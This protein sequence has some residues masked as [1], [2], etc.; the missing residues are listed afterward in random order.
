MNRSS[1]II[2]YILFGAFALAVF[3]YFRFPSEL[4]KDILISEMKKIEPMAQLETDNVEPSVPPGIKLSPLTISYDDMPILHLDS[5]KI[6]PHIFSMLRQ[7]KRFSFSGNLKDG[8]LEGTADITATSTGEQ[9]LG[10]IAIS[11][12]PLEFLEVLNQYPSFKPDGMMNAKINFDSTKGG[13]SADIGLEITPARI[14]LDPPL[15]DLDTL[16]F[17]LVKAQ[18]TANQRMVQIRSC[19]AGGDQIESKLTGA[20]VLRQPLQES[21]LTLSLTLRPLPAF[22]ADHKNDMIGGLLASGNAQKRGLIFR[23]SG[24][25]DKPRYVI[26]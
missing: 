14:A 24:T 22:L 3:L 12:M 7:T 10:D 19:E 20:I 16:E 26:R 11:R 23:I 25:L 5:L 15:M 13:G 18:L 17:S 4:M 9:V 8:A 6:T 1:K 2:L 21:R